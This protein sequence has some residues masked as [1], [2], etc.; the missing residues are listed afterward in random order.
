MVE[1]I[2]AAYQQARLPVPAQMSRPFT[3]KRAV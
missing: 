1:S 3:S 2:L